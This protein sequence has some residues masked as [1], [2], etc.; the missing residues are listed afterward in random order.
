MNY[1]LGLKT[2]PFLLR[3][4]SDFMEISNTSQDDVLLLDDA[5]DTINT[6]KTR[7]EANFLEGDDSDILLEEEQDHL[8]DLANSSQDLL[9]ESTLVNIVSH[10]NLQF[11]SGLMPAPPKGVL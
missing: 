9:A 3:V 1:D 6:L 8:C 7:Q 5:G 2:L 4:M 11:T 10:L